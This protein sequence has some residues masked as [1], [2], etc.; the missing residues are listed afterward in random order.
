MAANVATTSWL[1]ETA[2]A[3]GLAK[4]ATETQAQ[5][6][7]LDDAKATLGRLIDEFRQIAG[8]SDVA[9]M[10]GWEGIPPSPDL[11]D[12]L[13]EAAESLDSRPLNRVV[14]GLER[15]K[16]DV[17][18]AL[19]ECWQHY[20]ADRMGNVGDLQVLAQ[21][22]SQVDGVADLSRGLESILGEL[23]RTQGALP[24]ERSA[25]LLREAEAKLR[26]LEE[27]LQPESVR[28]F[29]SAVARGGASLELLTPDVTTWLRAHRA[30]NFRIVA[31]SPTDD[32]RD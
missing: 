11:P 20:A 15:Y 13:R 31:G 5:I 22:L 18:T 19:V 29:L 3:L 28:R 6:N 21:T 12:D 16:V 2:S 24:S 26:A 30:R 8:G 10:A 7:G 4:N 27:S 17:R 23:A 1:E 25:E 14:R 9:R 32:A